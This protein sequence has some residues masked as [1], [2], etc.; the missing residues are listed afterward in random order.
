MKHNRTY[1]CSRSNGQRLSDVMRTALAVGFGVALGVLSSVCAFSADINT[2]T[3]VSIFPSSPVVGQQVTVTWTV[4]SNSIQSPSVT[5][6]GNLKR[7]LR[8]PG[9]E[10][11]N[12][13]LLYDNVT[14]SGTT[15]YASTYAFTPTTVGIY[16]A[17]GVYD[18]CSGCNPSLSD[19]S[20]TFVWTVS[21][22]DT[23]TSVSTSPS[24]S[25]FG[26]SVAFTATV[27]TSGGGTPTGTV[28]FKDGAAAIGTGAV[29]AGTS[30]FTTM[31]L[32]V[33]THT[34]TVEY[35]GDDNYNGSTS[36]PVTQTV[37]ERETKTT[38]FCSDTALVVNDTVTCTCTVSDISEGITSVPTGAVTVSVDP[39]TQGSPTSWSHT[40]VAAD[41][42]Q[43]S[44]TYTP[45]SGETTTHVFTAEYD[46][47]TVHAASTSYN[48]DSL[49]NHDFNQEIIKRAVDIQLSLT[50]TSAY[51][52]QGVPVTVHVEDDT[53]EGTPGNLT[54]KTVTLSTSGP[55]GAGAFS[56][57]TPT[58]DANGNCTV[59]YT[60]AP[61]EAGTTTL[62][63][64]F[65]AD[66]VYPAKSAS[67]P[68]IVTLRP[69]QT[70][71]MC[72]M[73]P[74][75]VNQSVVNCTV[76]VVDIATAGT[77][78]SPAGTIGLSTNVSGTSTANNV[79]GPTTPD[80][81]E[82]QWEFDY[83][84]TGLND[85]GG[86]DLIQADF[87]ANNGIHAVST[88]G[89]AQA[90][91]RRPTVTTLAG[92]VST[93]TGVTCTAT[94]EEDSGNAG[95][96]ADLTGDFVLLGNP[97]EG[98]T[99]CSGLSGASPECTDFAV[100]ADSI[101]ANVVV[102]F[103]PTNTVHLASTASTNVNRSDQYD[104]D[105][106]DTADASHCDAGCGTGGI[107]IDDVIVALNTTDLNLSIVQMG[108]EAITII[109]SFLPDIIVGAGFGV[110]SGVTIPVSDIAA[111][112][113]GSAG[114][115]VEIARTAMTTDLDGDGLPL[116]VETLIGTSDVST[117]SDG[118]GIGDAEE[119][120]AAG[121]FFGGSRRPDP[122]NPDSDGDG[123]L[124][125]DEVNIYQTNFC[126]GDTDC[127]TI[128]DGLE[129]GT[130]SLPDERDHSDPLLQDTDGDGIRDDVQYA[131]NS[132][133]YIN[134]A[135]SDDDGLEDGTEDWN[136]DGVY[137]ANI[138]GTGSQA[139]LSWESNPC[140]FD[141]DGDG[142][143]DGE[144]FQLLGGLYQDPD[145]WKGTTSTAFILVD[146]I[147]P[148]GTTVSTIPALDTDSD[149][150]GLS[151]YEEVNET[152]TDPLDADTDNDGLNDDDEVYVRGGTYPNRVFDQES[153][154]LDPDTDDDGIRDDKEFPGGT[155]GGTLRDT[156][157]PYVNDDDSDDDGLQ[158]GYEIGSDGVWQVTQYGNSTQDGIGETD[159][160]N[161]DT[162][163]DGLLDGE[164]EGLFGQGSVN[165][166]G[167]GW[168]SSTVPA[169][170]TDCDRDG[171]SD[172]EEVHVT[173]TNP[174]HWD[175]DGDGISDANELIA[176]SA[177]TFPVFSAAT[178]TD[179]V[180]RTFYQESD[181]LDPDTDDDE[182][183]DTVEYDGT[184]LGDSSS[185]YWLVGGG[186]PDNTCPFVNDDDSD[187]DG[188][189]DGYEDDN[190]DG[191]VDATDRDGIWNNYTLPANGST[192]QGSGETNP[193]DPDTDDDGLSDG[194]EA[195]L[196]VPVGGSGSMVVS[197]T[198]G[199]TIPA[200]D[201]DSDNDGLSDYE[202]VN[203]TGTDPLD[204][205]TDGDGISDANELISTGGTWPK[206]NFDQESDP[207]D[208][209]TDDDGL[210]DNIE[211]DGSGLGITRESPKGDRDLSCPYVNDDD[212]DHDGL[213]DG[214][215]DANHDGTWGVAGVH[216][217][218]GSFSTQAG[219]NSDGYYETDLC[220]PDTD[221]DGLLDGEEV[222]LIGGG[223]IQ[224]RPTDWP[225]NQPSP[226]FNTVT[227][228]ARSTT[229]PLGTITVPSGY[230][231]T[232]PSPGTGNNLIAPYTFAPVAG[233]LTVGSTVPA[234]D[235]DSDNDGLSDYEEVNITGTDP[236]DQDTDNDTL[237]DADELIATGGTWPNRTFDQ[238]SDPLDINT[239]DDHLFDPQEY[240][241]SELGTTYKGDNSGGDPDTECPFVNDDDSD[242]DG[243][244]DGAVVTITPTGV[245]TSTGDQYSY[246]H[247]ED[248]IDVDAANL[249]YP[250]E[251][252]ANVDAFNGEQQNDETL[253]VCDSDSDGDGLN[254][255]EEIAI[256][257]NPDDCDTDDDGRNDWHEVT[258]GGPI[259]TDPFDPDTDDDGLLDSAEV[260][261]SN[262]TNPVNA[263]TDGDGLC[264]GGTGTPWMTSNDPRVIVNP[265]CKSCAVPGLTSCG[266]LIRTGS[267]DG[268][269]DHPN[270]HGYG[271]DKN[272]NGAWDGTIGQSWV[273]GAAGTQETDPNQY[274]TDGDGDGDGI[275]V[276][277]FSTSRQSWI[278][279]TDLFGRT[280]NVDYPDCGC[281]EP[282]IADTDGDGLSDGYED[283][284]HD[285]NFDFLPSDFEYEQVPLPGPPQPNPNETNPCD[286][287]TDDD[288][289]TDY[290]ERYQ[291]QD[292][293]LY[294]DQSF[295]FNPTNPLDHDTDNDWLLDG[296]EVKY[297][298]VELA[299]SQLDNDTDAA[300]NEDPVDG[301]DNDGDGLIDEDPVDFVIRF[302]PMLDPT[303]RDSDS[304]GFI[305]GLDDDPCNS[306]CIPVLL[307]PELLPVDT[308]GD[309]FSDDS[310]LAAGTH[311]NDPEDH[312]IAF[313]NV[314]LDFDQW[315]DDRIWLEPSICCGVANSVVIDIDSN[316]L[317]DF[318]LQIV[319]PRDV[320]W[321]DF[322]EDGAEDD[323]RYIVEYA[324]ANYRVLQPRI[325]ATIDDYNADLVIDWVVVERK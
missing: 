94:T 196:F 292:F 116:V 71:V 270:P 89:F 208:I 262:T 1:A 150:D 137:T 257:T 93:G 294:P 154:P 125:G 18:G 147:G 178:N 57:S 95:T 260:F 61:Y 148:S 201:D 315:I 136:A 235:V 211:W 21:K 8:S 62:T 173:M 192:G 189:Q 32:D 29:S 91:Q 177:G 149:D 152:G 206:R 23:T 290:D 82:S 236:L 24:S 121:G 271:E 39:N 2:S 159:A 52:G 280:I 87:T 53:T 325:V 317:I 250:G 204:A 105:V 38:V 210:T 165:V 78:T 22:A 9:T 253:N 115:L 85:M 183:L 185:A 254:D 126:V 51:I 258:G 68:L 70:T 190:H 197:T 223:P 168:T 288:D 114:I 222:S 203:I 300:I 207:L 123:L 55:G 112:I 35:G 50:P 110:I 174:L 158:D 142:L 276:L 37:V 279:A 64:T 182:L 225:A 77:A 308:D 30:M 259:P 278:P 141:T 31:T 138:A 120:S 239:D 241:G 246:T 132:C 304:D 301:I 303:N 43:F 4:E 99:G 69:T 180:A 264:D 81:D 220:N 155:V 205:D 104:T 212:S 66:N 134:E 49:L 34:I 46:G 10:S 47:S 243:I 297:V 302:V 167:D 109:T 238:E 295:P 268:I 221:G 135:D 217:A 160:C 216:A 287:D 195:G 263:D 20:G 237:M 284:N 226:G 79:S 314:D 227:P 285:G 176:T 215:E 311:P 298:C 282:L 323:V 251:A 96:K 306:E 286:A 322:D 234:L 26:E 58:L 191:V 242:N 320:E 179:G 244:Q 73:D 119:I 101:I 269:G 209:D 11:W 255:G 124:D 194:E 72:S 233:T 252:K 293:V 187:D 172:Y 100:V 108:L 248:F 84:C 193:C 14:P 321:G 224:D 80:T 17:E 45:D 102:R 274:D 214:V 275:E 219:V 256:G 231:H 27:S 318:R 5:I 162:D 202:E 312:P 65:A 6:G 103:D 16:T 170:D 15:P 111:A 175:T 272:G 240:A 296:F 277:G 169:L 3:E 86:F 267:V 130:W 74:I 25:L 228:E 299:C 144:E 266:T 122:T 63:A 12:W 156:D 166:V 245:I 59:T 265:I 184:R 289:L 33:G 146:V 229:L 305:D 60:P 83:V 163:N 36:A 307:P 67:Q 309:G 19:S 98:I 310:E 44:F 97:N 48:V 273:S 313:C 88:G 139:S 230:T 188:L 153:D 28:T 247:F 145:A 249:A 291:S 56:N 316:V 213:Q 281:L 13:D 107:N 41:A 54:G 199:N 198:A 324:F 161:E 118:D 157:C 164:E 181:P 319:Q 75:L 92:C 40:L 200:L 106:D 140:D 117:D 171:L 7:Q 143:A 129:V 186:D 151:D 218:V 128:S 90:V 283:N 131:S 127:D 113:T 232:A 133:M 76:T 261:G 42:G